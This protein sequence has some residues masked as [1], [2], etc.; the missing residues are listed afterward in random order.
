MIAAY[1]QFAEDD[2]ANPKTVT[3]SDNAG[4]EISSSRVEL[5]RALFDTRAAHGMFSEALKD[6]AVVAMLNKMETAKFADEK[7]TTDERKAELLG[8]SALGKQVLASRK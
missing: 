2:D 8:Q 4:K 6:E 5:L 7:K 1:S 3:F